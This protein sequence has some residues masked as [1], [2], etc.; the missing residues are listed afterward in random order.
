MWPTEDDGWRQFAAVSGVAGV[1][2]GALGP[3]VSLY[4]GTSGWAYGEWRGSFYPPGLSQARFLDH[5]GERLTAC[6]VNATFYRIQSEAAVAR[7]ANAVPDRFRFAV[8]AHRRL[9]Y[10]KQLFPDDDTAS[11]IRDFLASLRPFGEKLGCL[12]IQV[13][14]FLERDD[15]GLAQLLDLLPRELRF[16]CELQ[17]P[18]WNSVEVAS[19]LAGRGGTVCVRETEGALPATL[20]PGPLAYVRLKATHYTDEERDALLAT[21]SRE[22]RERDVF[23]FARHKDVAADDPYTGLGLARWLV[24]KSRGRSRG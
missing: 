17:H 23:V 22:A 4:A 21:L 2:L 1:L 18:S 8:K 12:L 13:P 14:A 5:Y 11:H 10:R 9:S 7:W 16:A 20:P 15:L 19:T 24:A 6:E 3:A